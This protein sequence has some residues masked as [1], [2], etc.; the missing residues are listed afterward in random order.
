MRPANFYAFAGLT[1]VVAVAAGLAVS[2]QTGTTSM[3]AGTEPAFP[4]L[5]AAINDVALI[6]LK[7][8]KGAFSMSRTGEKWGLDQKDGYPVDFE[9][10]KTAVV[11]LANFKLIEQKTSDPERYDRLDLGTPEG[12]GAKSKGIVLKTAK[13]DV[14]ADAVIG[15]VN[16][17]LFG[18]G[19][20]GTYIR[21]G[22]QKATWLVR[23]QVD[24]GDEP[25]MWMVR[26]IVNYGQE[27]VK[28][29]TVRHPDGAEVHISKEKEEDKNFVLAGIPEGRRIKAPDEANPLG[30][31]MWRM[32][33]DDVKLASKQ[34]WPAEVWVSHYT[35]WDGVTVRIEVAK[36]DKDFWGR[37]SAKVADGVTGEEARAKAQKIADEI[38]ARTAGWA[39]MLT[40][41]DAEKLTAKIDFYLDDPKK[42]GS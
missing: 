15:K 9:K 7:T 14:L 20:S 16:P 39:Y 29:V 32:M 23:G 24:L 17:N 41:G 42:K 33:F 18:S 38:S 25:N 27:H 26:Q 28:S 31:V 19:G 2:F 6:E 21:R 1:A 8:A 35:I 37:F 11:A 4:K 5:S 12:T 10:L 34:D 30:G 22:D 13:G 3:T 36:I 40:A